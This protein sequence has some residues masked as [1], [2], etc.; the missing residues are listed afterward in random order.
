MAS[1]Y[2]N[3]F[4]FNIM[5]NRFFIL[6]I[7]FSVISV[8]IFSVENF[9]TTSI[10]L[11][12]LDVN[13]QRKM[14]YSEMGR[15]VQVID[16][17]EISKL[18]VQSIDDVL[19]HFAGID[20][21]QR[22][23]NGTQSD[24]SIRG[25]SFDQVLVLMNGVNVTDPQTGHYNLDLPIDL[26]DIE[27]IEV[28][29]GASARVLGPNAFS[30]AINIVTRKASNELFRAQLS[31][32]SFNSFAQ[33]LSLG[34]NKNN[35]DVLA[36]YNR[37]TSDG[38]RDNTDYE[39]D[40]AYFQAGLLTKNAGKFNLQAFYQTKSYGANEFYTFAYPN[41]FDHTQTFFSSLNW[42]LNANK[43]LWSAQVSHRKHYD[44]FELFRNFENALSWYTSHNYHETDVLTARANASYVSTIGKFSFGAEARNE[45]IYSTVLGK[46]MAE[47]VNN[48]FENGIS[49]TKED[50][51]LHTT[52][53]FD[54]S[55]MYDKWFFSL[56][57]AS[58]NNQSFGTHYYGG[59]DI[60]YELNNELRFFVSANN[61]VRLPTFT[62]LY[63]NNSTHTSNP[64]LQ[65]ELAKTIELGA[66]LTEQQLHGTAIVFYRAGSNIIDWVR[67]LE[68]DKWESRNL[69]E[70]N[71]M[72]AELNMDYQFVNSMVRKVGF[73]YSYLHLDKKAEDYD[74]KYALDFMK[75]K[76][77]LTLD[78]SL[79]KN[80][81]L[82]W[83]GAIFDRSGNYKEYPS[84]QLVEFEPYA[85]VDTRLN[86]NQKRYDLFVDV[87]NVFNV[88]YADYGGLTQP[89]FN[90][91]AGI[92]L[93]VN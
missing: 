10:H 91:N 28:L 16:Q 78:H 52:G 67:K 25:G 40:N 2:C 12:Q 75:H 88:K 31:A 84:N 24:I 79:Y 70:V 41:Q 62:D 34:M 80:F 18:S 20:I 6:T 27:R 72:G 89:G 9:D 14:I 65:P 64:D 68:A 59:A 81:S 29:Q 19:K 57:A 93:R 85:L 87:N 63:Y 1:C 48:G 11:N 66:K 38:Y 8:S 43:W 22:G 33:S 73:A 50:S 46:P 36:T 42:E 15:V 56:G 30:G 53:Y 3:R 69:T 86:F 21:R 82:T 13:A 60:S 71:A 92:R 39:M 35:F 74:S 7:L 26:N 76:V 23:V 44:R 83:K 61:A 45:H 49:Y 58:T 47:V 77:V 5:R 54:Y 51:R 90:W 37:K 4:L 55:V 32:G 17:S